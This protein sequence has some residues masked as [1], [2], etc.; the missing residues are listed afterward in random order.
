[1]D[2]LVELIVRLMVFVGGHARRLPWLHYDE[3]RPGE[4]LKV[5]LVGYNGAH[6]T[7]ADVRV[8]AIADQVGRL[9]G[10]R[11]RLSVITLDPDQTRV[12]FDDSVRQVGISAIFFHT[13]LRECSSN[14]LVILC[15]GSTL[16]SKF[17]NALTLL[18]C[19][20][21]GTMRAQGKPCIAYGSEAGDMEPFLEKAVRDLCG[22]TYFIART[23]GSLSVI[24]TLGLAGHLGT[25]T[26]WTFD[27]SSGAARAET[28]LHAGGWDGG[29]PLLGVAVINPFWWPV[30]PSLTRLAKAFVTRDHSLR[31]QKWYFFTWSEERKARYEAYLDA[32]ADAV[33]A[34]AGARSMLP[35]LIGMEQLDRDAVADLARRL[36]ERGLGRVPSLTSREEDGFVISQVLEACSLLVTSRY[37]AQVLAM[38]AGVPTVAVSMDER[39]DNM[40]DDLG[41][42]DHLLLHVDDSDLGEGIFSALGHAETNRAE[43]AAR[44]AD[45]RGRFLEMFDDM[46]AFLVEFVEGRVPGFAAAPE[47]GGDPASLAGR[48]ADAR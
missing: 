7:G 36:S 45:R 3:W 44:I 39:L 46:G 48:E 13:L 31:F 9:F 16:K 43:I 29:Q 24:E 33:A 4:R 17:A 25:D 42:S 38:R 28:L 47:T 27:G 40:A 8:S 22:D 18:Y 26:A 11:V 35:V 5:L 14:H 6:N 15:E 1:M 23:A 30:R 12:Y 10:D 34:F 41:F 21:A 20:A 19:Q 2:R 37:H 32:M